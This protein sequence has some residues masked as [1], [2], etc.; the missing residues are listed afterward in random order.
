MASRS[1]RA[2][3]RR[4]KT[5]PARAA[6]S[7]AA[8]SSSISK[9][10]ASC[11]DAEIKKTLAEERPYGDWLQ[12][13]KITLEDLPRRPTSRGFV[14]RNAAR[15][16]M[17]CLGYTVRR[18]DASS[19]CAAWPAPAGSHRLDGQRRRR[20]PASPT[21][22]ACSTTTSSSP[23]PRSPT[24]RSTRQGIIVMSLECYIGPRQSAR[25]HAAHCHRLLDLQHPILTNE[26]LASSKEL[27]HRG[28]ETASIDIV[29]DRRG[30]A[31]RRDARRPR[32]HLRADDAG[33]RRRLQPRDPFRPRHG[34]RPRRPPRCSPSARSIIT[35]FA[36][37]A[38]PAS[39]SSWKP[40]KPA[41][42]TTMPCSSVT[43]RRHQSLP[44]LRDALA[45]CRRSDKIDVKDD[46][47]SSR[48]TSRLSTRACS[49]SCPRWASRRCSLQGG[50]D[51]RSHRP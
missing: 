49:K 29:F 42:C 36:P 45:N 18:S 35:S 26:G 48:I 8:C 16:A 3:R 10:A 5:S 41:K 6:S 15:L 38:A 12:E 34:P 37:T 33:N 1:R 7:P 50:A 13:Q 28:W 23:S 46:K 14:R 4:R 22:R 44:R 20:W 11:D 31:G 19:C 25:S 24:P 39:A 30:R 40:A 9:K 2:A 27:N 17:Q 43:A 51:L 21:S 32:P 47:T